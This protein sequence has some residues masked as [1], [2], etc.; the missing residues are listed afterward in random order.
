[1]PGLYEAMIARWDS[2]HYK[3]VR[4]WK[5]DEDTAVFREVARGMVGAGAV[6]ESLFTVDKRTKLPTRYEMIRTLKDGEPI[7]SDVTWR[8]LPPLRIL[9]RRP[10]TTSTMLPNRPLPASQPGTRLGLGV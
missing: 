1:M 5:E 8:S 2:P 7:T 10:D 4:P 3:A 6:N 9:S